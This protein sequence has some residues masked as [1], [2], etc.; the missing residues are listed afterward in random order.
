[1]ITSHSLQNLFICGVSKIYIKTNVAL[2]TNASFY[3]IWF[4][5]SFGKALNTKNISFTDEN[6]EKIL[7][8]LV[9]FI[10]G[11]LEKALSNDI[12]NQPYFLSWHL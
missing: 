5:V 7:R 10:F 12:P 6:M 9:A 2:I 4:T 3:T 11:L 1:M 8:I